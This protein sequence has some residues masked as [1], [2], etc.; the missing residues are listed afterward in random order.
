[1]LEV[2]EYT[3]EI[4]EL[5]AIWL[6]VFE[7]LPY[8]EKL[9]IESFQSAFLDGSITENICYLA[10]EDEIII[11]AAIIHIY[12][13][14]GAVLQLLVPH[15]KLN[16][17][18]SVLLLKKAIEL[19]KEKGLP[20]ISPKPRLCSSEYSEFFINQ[21]FII[22]EEYPEGLWMETN[23]TNVPEYL[24]SDG[25][26]ITVTDNLDESGDIENLARLE[27]EI[28]NE[29]HDLDI[30]LEKNIAALRTE[31]RDEYIVYGIAKIDSEFVG[32]SRTVFANLLS[33]EKIVKNR[34]LAVK[35]AHRSKS[36]GKG[37]LISSM[38]MVRNKGYEKMYISTHSKNPARFL[39]EK[40][41]FE[42]VETVKTLTY[43]FED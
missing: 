27:L 4:N 15:E 34:G 29:Q 12:P 32:Y 38:N 5:Y 14:W 7:N 8:T 18:F 30:E 10:R 22:N 23:F 21:G 39:Y 19:G 1:M 6:S 28:A 3:G 9:D 33:G 17:P 43:N 20:K 31:M 35:E 37:L 42:T 26:D 2:S 13:D 36:I 16:E 24:V 25:L 41:G 11:G 40:V